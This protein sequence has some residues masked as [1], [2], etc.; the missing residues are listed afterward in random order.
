MFNKVD[1]TARVIPDEK[2]RAHIFIE[3]QVQGV[4]YRVWCKKQAS[5]HDL[6]GWVRNTDDGRV[7]VVAEGEKNKL[8]KLI[9]LVKEGPKFAKVENVDVAYEKATGEFDSFEII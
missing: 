6:C 9:E 2:L 3:G 8:T 5:K 7:E 1:Q 4:F